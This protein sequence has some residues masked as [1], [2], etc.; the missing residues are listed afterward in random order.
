MSSSRIATPEQWLPDIVISANTP[1]EIIKNKESIMRYYKVLT[2]LLYHPIWD[3]K[4]QERSLHGTS[5]L[6]QDSWDRQQLKR[7]KFWEMADEVG[8]IET[9]CHEPF[10][11]ELT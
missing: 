7:N 1:P 8:L 5:I 3:E 2:Y 11:Y 10:Y 6:E 9:I 4:T